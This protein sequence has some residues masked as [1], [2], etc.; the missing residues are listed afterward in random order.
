MRPVLLALVALLLVAA[1]AVAQTLASPTQ[2]KY[3]EVYVVAGRVIDED[4]LPYA[5]GAVTVEVPGVRPFKAGVNCKGDFIAD[6]PLRSVRADS[7]GKVSIAGVNGSAGT[8]VEFGLDP[9]YR[10]NDV[11]L[12]LDGPWNSVCANEQ[13]VWEVSASVIVR[14]VNRTEPYTAGDGTFYARPYVGLVDLTFEA[15]NGQRIAPP[16]PQI[17]G[18]TERFVPDE[19]GDIRYTFTLDSGFTG[20]GRVEV[21]YENKTVM[22]DVDP[23]FRIA[24]RYIE[25]SGRGP[26]PELYE[27]PFPVVLAL[28]GLGVAAMA[29]SPK[30]R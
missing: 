22:V 12:R 4:G 21:E 19:R 1:P 24:S 7:V 11:Q 30:R 16:H 13:N 5:G 6:F 10:R 29:F 25:V 8:S 26:P 15:P 27:T 3:E 14:L 2:G 17:P 23:S 20:G 9:F 28:V 18:A